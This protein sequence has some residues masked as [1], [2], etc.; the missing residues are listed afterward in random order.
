[1]RPIFRLI[2]CVSILFS[3]SL[4]LRA[5]DDHEKDAETQKEARGLGRSSDLPAMKTADRVEIALEKTAPNQGL[6]KK[7]VITDPEELTKIREALKID[8]IAPSSG[9]IAISVRFLKDAKMLRQVWVYPNGE[10]GV[11]RLNSPSWAMGKN[12][13]LYKILEEHLKAAKK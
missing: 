5:A 7:A 8:E 9:Q 2:C 6:P 12:E 1:M 11:V 10:W 13:A 4:L 3:A